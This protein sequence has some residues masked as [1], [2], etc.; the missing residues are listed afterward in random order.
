MTVYGFPGPT[1][2]PVSIAEPEDITM[3]AVRK[4]FVAV[5]SAGVMLAAQAPA[6]ASIMINCH[7]IATV[8]AGDTC[9]RIYALYFSGRALAY[10]E[11]N[12]G[13]HC[14]DP[15]AAGRKICVRK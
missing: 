5:V 3:I 11:A 2:V 8:R 14:K 15:L 4:A 6:E 12:G 7:E 9:M 13:Q 10:A 1:I